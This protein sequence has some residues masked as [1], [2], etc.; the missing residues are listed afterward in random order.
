MIVLVRLEDWLRHESRLEHTLERS[1][2]QDTL[3][4]DA[5]S[6]S[7]LV[8]QFVCYRLTDCAL[9]CLDVRLRRAHGYSGVK[10]ASRDRL[11]LD[12]ENSVLRR[13]VVALTDRARCLVYWLVAR[14]QAL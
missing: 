1:F 4:A 10:S 5:H 3:L 11:S 8:R 9:T 7:L 2:S 12:S 13:S 14:W 6:S